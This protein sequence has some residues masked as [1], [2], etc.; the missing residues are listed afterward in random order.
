MFDSAI[1]TDNTAAYVRYTMKQLNMDDG[2]K[3]FLYLILNKVNIN[4]F[5]F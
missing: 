5:G 1:N 4:I 3:L 2:A